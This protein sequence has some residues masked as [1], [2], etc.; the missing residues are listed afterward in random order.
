MTD[1]KFS[2]TEDG[3]NATFTLHEIY[4]MRMERAE[5]FVNAIFE[6]GKAVACSMHSEEHF[7]GCPNK[8][9][10]EWMEEVVKDIE[11]AERTKTLDEVRKIIEDA[12][13]RD[14]NFRFAYVLDEISKLRGAKT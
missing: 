13:K 1:K 4:E 2:E 8:E 7:Y 12:E 6:K 5:E 9:C 11:K 10:H 14:F 3:V